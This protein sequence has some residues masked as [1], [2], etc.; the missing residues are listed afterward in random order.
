MQYVGVFCG[1]DVAEKGSLPSFQERTENKTLRRIVIKAK[2]FQ[3]RKFEVHSISEDLGLG[4]IHLSD[5]KFDV[6]SLLSELGAHPS[7]LFSWS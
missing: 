1:S 3:H 2:N 6:S 7:T 5:G 4:V